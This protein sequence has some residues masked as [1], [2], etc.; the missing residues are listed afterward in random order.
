[1][2]R[3]ECKAIVDREVVSLKATFGLSHWTIVVQYQKVSGDIP[4]GFGA[5]GSCRRLA[6]YE[7][8]TI[9]IDP[10][11]IEDRDNLLGVLR[12]ELMHVVLAPFDPY[13]HFAA[14]FIRKG[15][16]AEVQEDGVWDHACEQAVRNLERLWFCAERHWRDRIA[17]EARAKA[18]R[19]MPL[20]KGYSKASV[21]SNIKAEMKA[22]KPQK[23]AVAIALSTARAAAKKAGKAPKAGGKAKKSK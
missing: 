13:R 22:G 10:D 20:K 4:D 16:S 5:P 12:H 14:S 23:Q 19:K 15:S 1:M 3:S 17:A 9:T 11:E 2:D 6:A 21:S 7:R 8:A 18:R